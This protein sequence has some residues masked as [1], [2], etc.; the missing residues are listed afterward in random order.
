MKK[1][2]HFTKRRIFPIMLALVIVFFSVVIPCARVEASSIVA[3]VGGFSYYD[4]VSTAFLSTGFDCPLEKSDGTRTTF[5]KEMY[6]ELCDTFE[7]WCN[8]NFGTTDA[9]LIKDQL[10][11]LP[12]AIANG[13]VTISKDLW[14]ALKGFASDAYETISSYVDPDDYVTEDG[15]YT[16]AFFNALT[17]S[18]VFDDSYKVPISS[19]YMVLSCN[20]Y[21]GRQTYVVIKDSTYTTFLYSI[22]SGYIHTELGYGSEGYVNP[23]SVKIQNG[24]VIK[25][26]ASI[27]PPLTIISTNFEVYNMDSSEFIPAPTAPDVLWP[28]QDL[29]VDKVGV[30]TWEDAIAAPDVIVLE[31]EDA[32][33][34]PLENTGE[35]SEVIPGTAV[36]DPAVDDPAGDATDELVGSD[37]IAALPD[38]IKAVGD[39]TTLFPFCIPFDIVA[40]IKGMKA[41]KKAPVWEFKYYFKEIDYTFEVTVDMTDYEAYIKIFRSGF[42]IFY[43]ICLMLFTIR[44]S[45][46]IVKD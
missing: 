25:S 41:E 29:A 22:S 44:Y 2:M 9:D 13:A 15:Y 40:L 7:L 36:D 35:D 3:P 20:D 38:K 46:G 6:D 18:S 30:V 1:V 17:H 33:A 16:A 31:G 23:S 10:R 24:Q 26:N 19:R 39:V 43:I 14:E 37:E 4:L 34:I 28:T 8:D 11:A 5:G 12:G 32:I 27:C 45:S 42:V 21:Y